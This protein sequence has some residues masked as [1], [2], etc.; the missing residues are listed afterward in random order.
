[1]TDDLK[2]K[3]NEEIRIIHIGEWELKARRTLSE[4]GIRP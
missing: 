4:L 1:L 2:R 3:G